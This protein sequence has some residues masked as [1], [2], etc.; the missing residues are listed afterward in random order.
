MSPFPFFISV[1]NFLRTFFK[2]CK[3]RKVSN[4]ICIV[5][6]SKQIKMGIWCKPK[7][8]PVAVSSI[9]WFNQD[10]TFRK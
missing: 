8:I 7:T 9:S 5:F 2:S 10:A 1:D 3:Y 6:G 4:Y